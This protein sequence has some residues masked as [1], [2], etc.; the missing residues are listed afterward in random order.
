MGQILL[1]R[2]G[3]AS[4]GSADYD[5][6]SELGFEQARALGAWFAQTGQRFTRVASG[7]M[8]RQRQTADACMG[9][10]DAGLR[11]EGEWLVDPCFNEYD[12]REVLVRHRPEFGDPAQVRAFLDASSNP[13]ATFQ[14]VFAAAMSR[15]M[16][17]RYDAEYAETWPVFRRRCGEAL[18][19]LMQD[20]GRGES[21]A[22]FTSGGVIAALC[23]HLL[24][25]SD[26][27]T[28]R[29]SWGLVNSG[30][31]RILFQPGQASLSYLNNHAHLER[32][33]QPHTV[34]FR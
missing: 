33:G 29:L 1:V 15:W 24:D 20:A 12:H 25:M 26:R 31:T 5:R 30:V 28:A 6:L 11:P 2:H 7:S 22:V 23:Q 9:E 3:Q 10:L 16:S 19:R 32:L 13:R 8:L 14:D 4:F 27:A 18:E 21:V 17:G 34:T